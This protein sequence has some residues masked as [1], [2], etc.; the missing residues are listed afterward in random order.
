MTT[1]FGLTLNNP[2][3]LRAT[4]SILWRG[5][6]G[7]VN[8]FCC[9]DSLENGARAMAIDL[10]N[11]QVIHELDTVNQIISR[12]APE[13]ENNTTAY[14]N[15]V[16]ADMGV[17]QDQPLDLKDRGTLYSLCAA[18]WHHEQGQQADVPTLMAG[19]QRALGISSL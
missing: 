18:V 7:A 4:F 1:P 10:M 13:V 16:C 14:I 19:V 2:G 15:A 8:G 6:V 11:A 3:N 5:Q 12:Y 17:T 9:F